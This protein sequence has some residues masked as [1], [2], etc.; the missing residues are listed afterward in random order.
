M[1]ERGNKAQ[2]IKTELLGP[3]VVAAPDA[4]PPG[5]VSIRPA[6]MTTMPEWQATRDDVL[7]G[8]P[9]HPYTVEVREA[10]VG[11]VRRDKQGNLQWPD[12]WDQ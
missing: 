11:M 2:I 10:I 5:H 12:G 9:A 1:G 3:D 8:G 6:D 4:P 7:A